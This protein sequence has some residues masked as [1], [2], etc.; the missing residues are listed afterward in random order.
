[1]A[2]HN[3]TTSA[4]THATVIRGRTTENRAALK[5]SGT[6]NGGLILFLLI[7]AFGNST[8]SIED[9]A[10]VLLDEVESPQI[11]QTMFTTAY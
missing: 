3:Y 9:L 6:A 4:K 10:A 5:L 11:H 2:R 1:M 7:L 8:I